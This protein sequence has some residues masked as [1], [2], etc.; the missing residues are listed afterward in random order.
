VLQ[1]IHE[2]VIVR[3]IIDIMDINVANDAVAVDDEDR[4]L[5][6][7]FLAQNAVF[8]GDLAVRPK[9]A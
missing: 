6:V 7:P 2:F 1:F 8:L 9:I 3:L 5:R 4:A